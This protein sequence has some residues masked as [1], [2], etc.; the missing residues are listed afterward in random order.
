MQLQLTGLANELK[1]VTLPYKSNA[2]KQPNIEL[3]SIP[4]LDKIVA[5]SEKFAE[6]YQNHRNAS[7]ETTKQWVASKTKEIAPGYFGTTLLTPKKRES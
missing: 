5:E 3:P 2:S 7:M 6:E 1:P 4:N